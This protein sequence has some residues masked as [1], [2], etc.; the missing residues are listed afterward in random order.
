MCDCPS[1]AELP[2]DGLSLLLIAGLPVGSLLAFGNV[3][4]ASF[5]CNELNINRHEY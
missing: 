4:I 3:L 2:I 5:L 1:G